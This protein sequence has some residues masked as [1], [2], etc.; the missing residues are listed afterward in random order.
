MAKKNKS[1]AGENIKY[2][3]TDNGLS[4]EAFAE[5]F[6]IKRDNLAKYE[7]SKAEPDVDFISV[8]CETYGYSI[9]DFFHKRLNAE[10]FVELQHKLANQEKRFADL[11]EQFNELAAMNLR[12]QK[13]LLDISDNEEVKK[14]TNVDAFRHTDELSQAAEPAAGYNE[15]DK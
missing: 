11:Q 9:E 7:T 14:A 15:K 2:V 3:R 13:K 5:K 6:N 10:S 1:F 12:L 4:Q 8:V